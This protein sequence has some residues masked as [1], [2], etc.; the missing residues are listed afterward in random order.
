MKEAG[1]GG[2]A[3]IELATSPVFDQRIV[4]AIQQMLSEAGLNVKIN[5]S[6]MASYLKRAQG[7]I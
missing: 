3:E 6:D 7:G 5:M 2:K 4:Q 1:E